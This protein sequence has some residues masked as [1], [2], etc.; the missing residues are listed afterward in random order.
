MWSIWLTFIIP[1]ALALRALD[2][3]LASAPTSSPAQ[4]A[5]NPIKE[6]ADA[7]A[8]DVSIAD[9]VGAADLKAEPAAFKEGGAA[10]K[11]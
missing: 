1:R 7:S 2:A 11:E 6:T 4:D 8:V 5:A 10:A 3:R 9:A